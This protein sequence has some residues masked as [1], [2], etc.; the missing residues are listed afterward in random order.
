M[1]AMLPGLVEFYT[2]TGTDTDTDTDT[3]T[4]TGTDTDENGGRVFGVGASGGG[5]RTI[6]DSK[7]IL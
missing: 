5:G 4:D 3:G 1:D 6:V 7:T 2:G